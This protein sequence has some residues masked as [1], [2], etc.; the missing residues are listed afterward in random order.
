VIGTTASFDYI[1]RWALVAKG[2]A[3]RLIEINPEETPMTK[4]ATQVIH[5]PA[6][7]SLPALVERLVA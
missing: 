4:F 5:T 1:V 3:G 6:A 7:Q 2:A